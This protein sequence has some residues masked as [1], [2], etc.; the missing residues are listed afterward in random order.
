MLYIFCAE[1]WYIWQ[2]WAKYNGRYQEGIDEPEYVKWKKQLRC[3]LHKSKT[4]KYIKDE[5]DDHKESKNP[6]RIY[7]MICHK[8]EPEIL[9]YMWHMT[10]LNALYILTFG[11][12]VVNLILSVMA[13]A[14]ILL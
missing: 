6:F 4:F 2:E 7:Q 10:F 3:A 8:G 11:S 12:Y 5:S 9:A 1:N 13:T 14:H